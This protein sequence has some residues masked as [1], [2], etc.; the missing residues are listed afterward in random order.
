MRY[1]ACKDEMI[2]VF[3]HREKAIHTIL[4]ADKIQRNIFFYELD[5]IEIIQSLRSYY[6]EESVTIENN[7]VRIHY[8]RK[9]EIFTIHQDYIESD[10]LD[11][12][13]DFLT[14]VHPNWIELDEKGQVCW[15]VLVNI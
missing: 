6:G 14:R 8:F 7:Q 4:K 11:Y 13:F 5:S 15:K 2:P 12:T 1:Y 9:I 3:Y 10:N